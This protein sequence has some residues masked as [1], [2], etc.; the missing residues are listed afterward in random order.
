MKS[1]TAVAALL[2]LIGTH[3]VGAQTVGSPYAPIVPTCRI[4][5]DGL[6]SAFAVP[7]SGQ[8]PPPSSLAPSVVTPQTVDVPA[9]PPVAAPL[10]PAD[11]VRPVLVRRPIRRY[12]WLGRGVVGQ[13]KL[14][15][16]GQPVRNVL[17]FLMP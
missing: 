17:R 3:S 15:V 14:Y 2:L 13:P 16:Q 7:A 10:T 11:G 12:I 6:P 9:G 1:L 8:V 5:P 4:V